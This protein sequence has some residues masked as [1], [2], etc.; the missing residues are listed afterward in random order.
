MSSEVQRLVEANGSTYAAEKAN[1][2][3][4]LNA[5][6]FNLGTARRQPIRWPTSTR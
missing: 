2:V 4:R 1:L 3:A 6:A 5:P